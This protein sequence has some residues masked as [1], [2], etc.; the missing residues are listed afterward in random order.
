MQVYKEK[1]WHY[2]FYFTL[3]KCSSKRTIEKSHCHN[4]VTT[5]HTP[6]LETDEKSSHEM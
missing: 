1:T 4:I 2:D 6:Y 5:D 3:Q